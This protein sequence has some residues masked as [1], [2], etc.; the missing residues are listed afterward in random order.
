MRAIIYARY[1]SDQQS[2]ASIDDQL[3][4]CRE[5]VT[6]EGWTLQQ[7]YRDAAISG[8]SSLRPG[9]QAVL[10]CARGAECDIVVAEALDR[11]SRDQEDVAALFKRCRFAGVRIITLAEGEINELHVGLK[12]TMNALFLKDLA[13]KTRRGLRGRVEAGNSGG[14]VTYG[15][16][17]VASVE[18]H[19][20]RRINNAQAAVVRR[21]FTEYRDGSSPKR[22]ALGLNRDGVLGPRVGDWAATTI[23]GNRDRGTG[24]L[25]NELYV[26]RLVWNRLRYSK[27]PD[28]GKRRSRLNDASAI[29]TKDVPDLRII[30]DKLWDAVRDRQTRGD[31]PAAQ[32]GAPA[33]AKRPFWSK[34]R[35]K[36]LFSGLMRCGSCGG[37]YSKVG[38]R[39]F[40]CSTAANKGFTACAN[41][42]TVR[43]DRLEHTVLTGLR[44]RLMDP[45]LFETF[46]RAFAAEWNKHQSSLSAEITA[47]RAE[48]ARVRGQLEKLVDAICNGTPATIIKDRMGVLESRRAVLEA[49][50]A[51]GET[52]APRLHP[53]L[54][55]L[56][57]E[58]VVALAAALD[59]AEG[60]STREVVRSL[61]EEIRLVPEE[62]G[63]RI[64]LRGELA[65]ILGLAG[66]RTHSTSA[67]S[68][69]GG[70]ETVELARKIKMVAGRRRPPLPSPSRVIRSADSNPAKGSVA[71]QSSP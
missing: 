42:L 44:E 60:A 69:P 43:Q 40:G 71:W 17:V 16:D 47:R 4:L 50:L 2:A 18:H 37:G 66:G 13:D 46:A 65:S 29:V 31:R 10:E 67:T 56:Y 32:Q 38:A 25:N 19:G 33:F 64:E 7:V 20:T 68:A 14:G 54:A 1:S 21:I 35:P 51:N 59:G 28:T 34:T 11:L 53:N 6:R 49:E 58:K 70:V 55:V 8:A 57:R 22:I 41:R 23:N 3:R 24:I 5:R 27:D 30:D 52:P 48:L 39:H 45:V 63:L 36:H 12:G 62:T 61:V 9:Y 26:G 15:Y